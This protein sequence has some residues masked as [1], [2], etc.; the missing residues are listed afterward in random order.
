MDMEDWRREELDITGNR[1]RL[2]G[3]ARVRA[4][5]DQL[6][7]GEGSSGGRTRPM[8]VVRRAA[9]LWRVGKRR[10]NMVMSDFHLSNALGDTAD[11]RNIFVWCH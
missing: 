6:A 8:I 11:A 7:W 10:D 2:L 9:V 1:A 3:S 4:R 5:S